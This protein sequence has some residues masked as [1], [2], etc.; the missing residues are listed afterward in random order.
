MA[1]E[2]GSA[3]EHRTNLLAALVLAGDYAEAAAYAEALP[4]EVSLR[5]L[6]L[7]FP[8]LF[9]L[10]NRGRLRR[11]YR[12]RRGSARGGEPAVSVSHVSPLFLFFSLAG[13][14]AEAAAYAEALPEDLSLRFLFILF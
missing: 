9:F 6:F 4:E 10:F 7:M 12:L 11:G 8:P 2:S 5:F 14:Y 1:E 3:S 13:D